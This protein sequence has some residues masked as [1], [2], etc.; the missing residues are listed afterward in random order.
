MYNA[1]VEVSFTDVADIKTHVADI[2]AHVAASTTRTSSGEHGAPNDARDDA[3]GFAADPEQA[4]A[5]GDSQKSMLAGIEN[6]KRRL[7]ATAGPP[8]KAA[9]ESEM[10]APVK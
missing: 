5:D 2:T 9:V 6:L 7:E 8:S 4:E 1:H 3:V 10:E